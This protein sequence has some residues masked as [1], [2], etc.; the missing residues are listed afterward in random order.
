MKDF[1]K[2]L[3]DGKEQIG[4]QYKD[5]DIIFC[6]GEFR[7]YYLIAFLKTQEELMSL[8]ED[9][10]EVFWAMR[11]NKDA[12]CVDMEKN[13]MCIYCVEVSEEEYYGAEETGAISELSKKVSLIE[14]DLNYF[15]KHVLLYTSKMAE[16]AQQNVG[17]FEALCKDYIVDQYFEEF[18]K[19]NRENYKYDFLL[20]LFIKFPFLH[21]GEYQIKEKKDYETVASVVQ[22]KMDDYALDWKKSQEKLEQ[23]RKEAEDED[24]FY[25]WL[26]N[27]AGLEHAKEESK[28]GGKN[29]N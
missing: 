10:S 18:K 27:L 20:N 25:K 11:N 28:E 29:E 16:F 5:Y 13:T 21:F 9:T 8:W 15:A 1:I 3:F 14:E 26:D 12:Y 6:T 7:S 2:M 19:N 23:V 24:A 22:K 4:F 17:A